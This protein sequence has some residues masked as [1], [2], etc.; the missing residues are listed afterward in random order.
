MKHYDW[1]Q[2]QANEMNFENPIPGGYIVEITRVEDVEEKE[3]LKIEWDFTEGIFKGYNEDTYQR[4]GFWPSTLFRSYKESAL[5]FFK[6]FISAVEES[7]PRYKFDDQNLRQL[8]GKKMGVVLGEES[9]TKS[10][11]DPGTRLYVYQVRS[12]GA[13][14]EGK[15]KIP[16]KKTANGQ[17]TG[18]PKSEPKSGSGFYPVDDDGP[19][20]F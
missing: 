5:G 19:L 14:A 3:Y 12:V 20:P 1:E 11:G 16:P 17:S 6:A 15:Y 2:I 4:A 13:I 9:Y 8:V 7:N 18:T 10:N